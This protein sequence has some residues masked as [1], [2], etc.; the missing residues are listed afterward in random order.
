MTSFQPNWSQDY[1]S[2][3][4]YYQVG[5]FKTHSKVMAMQEACGDFDRIRYHFMEP[6]WDQLDWSQEPS[7][8]FW[9]LMT[10]HCRYLRDTY[11]HLAVWYSGGYDSQT[12]IDCF[13]ANQL[14]I[15]EVLIYGRDYFT[16]NWIAR[17]EPLEAL[18]LALELKKSVWPNLKITRVNWRQEDLL[19]F[20]RTHGN[21]WILRQGHQ[22]SFA[23]HDRSYLYNY[24]PDLKKIVNQNHRVD[25]EGREKPRLW[26]ED[27]KWFV[28]SIDATNDPMINSRSYQFYT[29]GAYPELHVKQC[30]M[31]VRWI[32]SLPWNSVEEARV[33]LHSLQSH[34]ESMNTY[35]DWNLAIGRSPVRTISGY[36]SVSQGSKI[37]NNGDVTQTF[38]SRKIL[39]HVMKND[40][41]VYKIYQQG[42]NELKTQ[43]TGLFNADGSIK[44][45]WGKKYYIKPV[46]IASADL[47]MSLLSA[48]G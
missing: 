3:S 36:A 6:V 33:F 38:E 42:I 40:P 9:Q 14:V 22:A 48:H 31:M 45:C 24:N 5:E 7:Q 1:T 30:W 29:C 39:Q 35:R 37:W 12:I 21:Q 13:V 4:I 34:K 23:K 20:Y 47:L 28:S 15:D 32:E 10:D 27:G 19:T 18:R 8:D 44:P 46:E 43:Y 11:S 2:D 41:Q 16:D 17:N 25:I 26:I